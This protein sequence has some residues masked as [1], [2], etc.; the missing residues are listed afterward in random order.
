MQGIS[1]E[2]ISGTLS[3]VRDAGWTDEIWHTDAA[4]LDGGLQLALLWTQ[5][6]LGGASL[7]TSVGQ[8]HSYTDELPSGPVRC[9]LR[10]RKAGKLRTLSDLVF[11]DESGAVLFELR[12]VETHLTGSQKGAPQA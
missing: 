7:P 6:V 5:H 4:A 11:T 2:G 12:D 9:L 10:G 8:V 1:D 3:G